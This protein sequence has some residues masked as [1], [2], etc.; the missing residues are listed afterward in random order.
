MIWLN[1]HIRLLLFN[2]HKCFQTP[3][4]RQA[5]KDSESYFEEKIKR[6]FLDSNGGLS[7]LIYKPAPRANHGVRGSVRQKKPSSR[8]TKEASYMTPS[9]R[10][11]KNKGI[12][13]LSQSPKHTTSTLFLISDYSNVQTDKYY[14]AC[15]MELNDLL[16]HKNT[17]FDQIWQL[18]TS[19]AA[20]T[21]GL[22]ETA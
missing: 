6:L 22:A 17:W 16:S 10:S 18:E 2:K 15:D 1:L 5:S 9:L 11:S 7:N 19:H 3:S 8:W 12:V 21:M 20:P 4:K 14:S 13:T